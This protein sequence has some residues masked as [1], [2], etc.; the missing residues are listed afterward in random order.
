MV[1][2][3]LNTSLVHVKNWTTIAQKFAATGEAK[4]ESEND[5]TLIMLETQLNSESLQVLLCLRTYTRR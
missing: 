3:E 1:A 2:E 5:C 4:P